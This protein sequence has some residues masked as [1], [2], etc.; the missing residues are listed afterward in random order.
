VDE[1]VVLKNVGRW[2]FHSAHSSHTKATDE[3]LELDCP[4]V[5]G[6]VDEVVMFLGE[7]KGEKR[8]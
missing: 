1:Y 7:L 4:T 6:S 5:V 8:T 3:A 2:C